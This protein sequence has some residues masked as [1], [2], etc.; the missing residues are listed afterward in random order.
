MTMCLW[1]SRYQLERLRA[2][3]EKRLVDTVEVE[4][5]STTLML[6]DKCNAYNLR[7]VRARRCRW[8]HPVRWLQSARWLCWLHSVRWSRCLHSVRCSHSVC[9]LHSVR[10]CLSGGRRSSRR[11]NAE[12]VGERRARSR[13]PG[14]VC[15]AVCGARACLASC[16]VAL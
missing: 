1:S 11:C 2:I 7:Q 4:T 16:G 6:A 13:V 3:C 8:P 14:V 5:V 10:V 12:Q 9:C 15:G